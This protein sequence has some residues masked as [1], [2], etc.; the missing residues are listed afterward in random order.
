MAQGCDHTG[1]SGFLPLP[2]HTTPFVV[3]YQTMA[4]TRSIYSHNLCTWLLP[5]VA[6]RVR[7]GTT[8]GTISSFSGATEAEETPV[9]MLDVILGLL[10]PIQHVVCHSCI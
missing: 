1:G 5:L 2:L 3:R 4:L 9:P 6:A 7:K 8:L 10:L